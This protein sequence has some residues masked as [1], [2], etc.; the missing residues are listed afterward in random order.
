L[1]HF[2]RDV[3]GFADIGTYHTRCVLK[4]KGV[5]DNLDRSNYCVAAAVCIEL[6]FSGDPPDGRRK[7]FDLKKNE[8]CDCARDCTM[9]R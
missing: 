4:L 6:I 8:H 2:R 9:Y 1:N 5:N 7:M 3:A